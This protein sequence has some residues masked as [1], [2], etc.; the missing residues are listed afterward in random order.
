VLATDG[1]V[2]RRWLHAAMVAPVARVSPAP[3]LRGE[4]VAERLLADLESFERPLVLVIDDLDELPSAEIA[5]ELCVS[6]NTVRTHLRHAYAKLDA[7]SRSE[8][9]TRARQTGLLGSALR[10]R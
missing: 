6:P 10:P 2:H 9:V 7:H 1:A 5:H 4:L 8:A 3:G